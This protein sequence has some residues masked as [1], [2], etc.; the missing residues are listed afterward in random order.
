L[1]KP[2]PPTQPSYPLYPGYTDPLIARA[3]DMVLK[4]RMVRE[5]HLHLGHLR[6]M[7]AVT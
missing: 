1:R 4:E 3:A 6:S 7:A 5:T 2:H